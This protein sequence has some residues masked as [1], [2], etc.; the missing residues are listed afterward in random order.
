MTVDKMLKMMLLLG[1]NMEMLFGGRDKHLAGEYTKEGFF[2]A[3]EERMSKCL[4][5]AGLLLIPCPS[6]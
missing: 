6:R 4:A 1:S 2:L 3:V 5:S